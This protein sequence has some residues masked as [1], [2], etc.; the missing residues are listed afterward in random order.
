MNYLQMI[1]SIIWDSLT[2]FFG[3]VAAACFLACLVLL[4]TELLI[5]RNRKR[6]RGTAVA[7]SGAENPQEFAVGN[8]CAEN[9][10]EFAIGNQCAENQQEAAV[11]NQNDGKRQEDAL[12]TAG[13]R[14]EDGV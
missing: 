13:H 5:Y 14:K 10:Q 8:Q 4:A 3:A 12:L 2:T 11:G 9:Q 1:F 7:G 6:K